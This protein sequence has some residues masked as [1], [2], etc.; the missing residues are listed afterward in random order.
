MSRSLDS[1]RTLH[2]Q[3]LACGKSLLD[4]STYAGIA[5]WWNTH[6]MFYTGL[7]LIGETGS[8][9]RIYRFRFLIPLFSS[10]LLYSDLI[11]SFLLKYLVVALR[12]AGERRGSA[13][14]SNKERILFVSTDTDW[15]SITDYKSMKSAKGDVLFHSTIDL[16]DDKY[17]FVGIYPIDFY[18]LRGLRAAWEKWTTGKFRFVSL[19]SHWTL[20]IWLKQRRATAHFMRAWREIKDDEKLVEM[21]RVSGIELYEPVRFSLELYFLFILPLAVKYTEMG[22]NLVRAERPR[23]FLIKNEYGWRERGYAVIAAKQ[24]GVPTVALQHGN[25][26]PRHHGYLYLENELSAIG[27]VTAPYCPLPDLTAVYGHYYRRL[28]TEVSAYEPS[29]LRV[30]GQPRYDVLAHAASLFSRDGYTSAYDIDPTHQIVLWTTQSHGLGDEENEKSWTTVFR[31]MKQLENTTLVIKQ[32]PGEG[33]DYTRRIKSCLKSYEISAVVAPKD[34]DTYTHLA[35][36]DVMIT[37]FSTTATEAVILGKPV[38]ILN[39]SGDPDRV[40]YVR[41]GV[42]YGVYEEGDLSRAIKEAVSNKGAFEENRE[43]FKADYVFECDGRATTRVVE[44][45]NS[46]LDA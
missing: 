40:D 15:R 11:Y 6:F 42:A 43:R 18:P 13:P 38:I 19:N 14:Q 23:L 39:L 36:C 7:D 37:K 1:Y 22:S 9:P 34:S 33:S 46:V 31:A 44:L 29:A 25:I 35:C 16:L 21:C 32:H 45:L 28:L 5:W 20:K 2:H 12:W 4:L 26:Y 3:K 27:E 24:Q 8:K 30:T 10:L 41:Q 17:E